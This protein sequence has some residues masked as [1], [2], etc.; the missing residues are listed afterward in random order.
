MDNALYFDSY[1][2]PSFGDSDLKLSFFGWGYDG[3]DVE[4]FNDNQCIQNHYEKMIRDTQE[5]FHIEDYEV[6]Q[7]KRK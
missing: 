4:P 5:K 1:Y 2:G 3:Y 6:F 7:I